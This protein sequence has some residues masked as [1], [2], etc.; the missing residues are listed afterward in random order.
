VILKIQTIVSVVALLVVPSCTKT[1]TTQIADQN[2]TEL[3]LSEKADYA[4]NIGKIYWLKTTVEVCPAPE[5]IADAK[6]TAGV[7]GAQLQVDGIEQG[8][9]G[10]A[11][12]HVKMADGP[13][14]YISATELL[15]SATDIDPMK[16]AADCIHRGN[17]RVGM[18]AKQLKAT[19]WGEPNRVDHRETKRGTTERYVYGKGKYVLLHNGIVTSVQVSGTLR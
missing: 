9:A 8:P 12:Y 18:T 1:T 4:P 10:T 13:A 11:Y 15:A 17:P 2:H 16:T 5:L 7:N 3:Y 6:C 14:G 19:C